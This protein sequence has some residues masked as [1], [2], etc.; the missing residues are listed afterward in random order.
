M[1]AEERKAKIMEMI[2]REQ[3]VK[4]AEL[5]KMFNTTEATIR[6]DLD[7]LQSRNMLRRIHGG[8]IVV[9][10]KSRDMRYSDLSVL[11][12][13]EKRRIAQ[14]AIE[15]ICDEDTLLFDAS[16]T[17]YE[18]AR[19]ILE[20]NLKNIFIVTNS[21]NLV[22]LFAGSEHRVVHTGGELSSNMYYAVGTITER[23]MQDVRTDKCFVGA[24]GIDFS[25]GYSVPTFEDASVKKLMIRASR[26]SFVLADHTKFGET[27]M[28]KFA[29]YGNGIDYLITDLLPEE[30]YITGDSKTE[31]ILPDEV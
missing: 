28:A 16:T 11:H 12:I 1:F 23:M 9:N 13:E 24:N 29:D 22:N 7:E 14:K 6:R 26:E 30:N 18:L 3:V 4:V 25:Y 5:S 2:E 21:F 31:I 10:Q 15:Y 27:Y 8:A 19:L 17:V 20:S